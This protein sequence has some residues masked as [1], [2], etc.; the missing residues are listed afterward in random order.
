ML[1]LCN[2][3]QGLGPIDVTYCKKKLKRIICIKLTHLLTRNIGVEMEILVNKTTDSGQV[4]S[5]T[6]VYIS[7]HLEKPIKLD[8]CLLGKT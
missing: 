6:G 1:V 7:L 5:I 2:Q 4:L 8:V 3:P